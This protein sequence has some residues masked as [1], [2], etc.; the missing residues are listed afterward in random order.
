VGRCRFILAEPERHVDS[1]PSFDRREVI[2]LGD[3]ADPLVPVQ[4]GRAFCHVCV[5]ES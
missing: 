2:V 1:Q 4:L 5:T 3:H